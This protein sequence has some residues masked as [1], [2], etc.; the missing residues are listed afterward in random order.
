MTVHP[1]LML[2]A[3]VLAPL[4]SPAGA[5][6]SA[7]VLIDRCTASVCVA[8]LTPPQLLAEAQK[9]VD[10]GR[11]AEA[12]PMLAALGNIPAL[13]LE[14]RFLS[15]FVAAKTGDHAGAASIYK[16]ILSDDPAQTRVRLELAREMLAMGH[17]ASADRQFKIAEQDKD[18]PIDVAR[19]IRAVRDVIRSKRAW[20]ID[21]DFGLVPDSNI[22][23][24]T[25]AD[26]I[27]V[28]WGGGTLPLT[29]DANAKARSGL[30][31]T[32]S[33]SAGVRLPIAAKASMLVDF[34]GNGTNYSGASFD[35]YQVQL[36]AGPELRLS[37]RVSISAEAVG[38]QRWYGGDVVSR[39]SGVKLGGQAVLGRSDRVGV[40]LDLRHTTALFD[41]DYSGWQG[42]AYATYEHALTK[43]LVVST[44]LFVRRDWLKAETYSSTEIGAIGGIGGELPHGINFGV[45]GTVSRAHYDAAMWLF[46]LEPRGD[47]RYTARATLGNRKIRVFGFSPQV[48][49]SYTR[50]DC[51]IAYYANERVRV[52]FAL[53]RYF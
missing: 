38:A 19:T 35:D 10:A 22:N 21:V 14:T 30:G 7:Q 3:L 20:R 23:N 45:S 44:G 33:I 32:A 36:A 11:Y 6:Q 25:G 12:R 28:L 4:A 27:N 29:L 8:Q 52:R 51:S 18:L 41:R 43:S 1:R 42:S 16:Q 39:Q 53:A 46:S 34:D 26:T 2:A 47:W 9:L 50:T 37:D 49:V 31:E 5:Q 17:A 13:R 40:Q 24:A 48:S 15:G